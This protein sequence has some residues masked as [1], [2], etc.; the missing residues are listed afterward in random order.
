M[1]ISLLGTAIRPIRPK[2]DIFALSGL[3]D[4]S[5]ALSDSAHDPQ[6]LDSNAMGPMQCV[7]HSRS[8]FISCYLYLYIIL[9]DQWIDSFVLNWFLEQLL[10]DV[11]RTESP[12]QRG[13]YSQTLWFWSVMF[14]ACATVT[15]K[16]ASPLEE[17]QMRAMRDV[18]MGK[19]NFASQV[20]RIKN[21]EGAKSTM[22][23]FAWEDDF[24]GEVELRSLWEEAVWGEGH[25]QKPHS[26]GPG[27]LK[28]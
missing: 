28:G 5:E 4:P 11:C 1:V 3:D 12:M 21:W 17:E 16:V 9:R 13:Q 20:L 15:A 2:H 6:S 22:R 7:D 26:L 19:I 25:R 24:D 27:F 18:Y 8:D 14:G 10:A 23:L